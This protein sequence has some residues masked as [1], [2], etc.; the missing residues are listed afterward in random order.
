[1]ELMISELHR[2]R[3]KNLIVIYEE[4]RDTESVKFEMLVSPLSWLLSCEGWAGPYNRFIS[5]TIVRKVDRTIRRINNHPLITYYEKPITSY[6]NWYSRALYQYRRGFE[7]RTSLNFF[8]LSFRN[9]KSCVYNCDDL[10]FHI[11]LQPTVHIYDFHIFITSSPSF[12]GFITNQ[13]NDNST[14]T[15]KVESSIGKKR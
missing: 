6:L 12:H 14:R 15:R 10:L 9:C 7:S 11:I 13:F 2:R 8:R 1:M 5:E 4:A 3:K